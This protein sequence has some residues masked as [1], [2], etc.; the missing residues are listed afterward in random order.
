V[1]DGVLRGKLQGQSLGDRPSRGGAIA[2]PDFKWIQGRSLL[3]PLAFD[4]LGDYSDLYLNLIRI[5][6]HRL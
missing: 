4:L 5:N 2:V 3:L 6:T 1:N